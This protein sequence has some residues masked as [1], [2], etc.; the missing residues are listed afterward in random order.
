MTA[1]RANK[2]IT[3]ICTVIISGAAVFISHA[4]TTAEHAVADFK[5]NVAGIKELA[6]AVNNRSAQDSVRIDKLFVLMGNR[7]GQEVTLAGLIRDVQGDIKAQNLRMNDLLL[8]IN[9]KN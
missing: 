7:Q 2:F 9:K 1:T 6:I 4:C 5:N 3:W 8:I